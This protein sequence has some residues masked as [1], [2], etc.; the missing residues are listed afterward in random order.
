MR[1]SCRIRDRDGG[2]AEGI[3][4]TQSSGCDILEDYLVGQIQMT[5]HGI[6]RPAF[7]GGLGITQAGLQV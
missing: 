2:T 6:K 4:Y 7:F 5:A 1:I 3:Q